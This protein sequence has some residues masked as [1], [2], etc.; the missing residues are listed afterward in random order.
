[1]RHKWYYDL[2]HDHR[3]SEDS[4]SLLVWLCDDCAIQLEADALVQIASTDALCDVPCWI[5]ARPVVPT[6]RTIR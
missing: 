3:F 2:T 4:E 5:C 1:M 6:E